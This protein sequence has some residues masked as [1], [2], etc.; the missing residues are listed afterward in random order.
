MTGEIIATVAES[1]LPD[2]K[3]APRRIAV[4][5]VPLPYSRPLEKFVLPSK[6]KIIN[7][8]KQMI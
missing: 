1:S 3:A 2:L 7:T 8:I 5:D 4:P 6:D